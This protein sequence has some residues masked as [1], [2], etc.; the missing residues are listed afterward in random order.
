MTTANIVLNLSGNWKE[1]FRQVN[2]EADKINDAFGKIDDGLKQFSLAKWATDAA[3][4][5]KKSTSGLD[6]L[7][8]AVEEVGD[9]LEALRGKQGAKIR[10]AILDNVGDPA[11]R[12]KLFRKELEQELTG[13]GPAALR[14]LRPLN[15]ALGRSA[16]G[17][18]SLKAKAG[19]AGEVAVNVLRSMGIE[20]SS[21]A[22]LISSAGLL[23]VGA[24]GAIAVAAGGAALA[25]GVGGLVTSVRAY[26]ASSED[27][28]E[29]TEL[30][31]AQ[32]NA[33]K[34]SVG[35]LAY[36]VLGL[37][38]AL[39]GLAFGLGVA[40]DKV[41]G[42]DQGTLALA[43]EVNDLFL[44]LLPLGDV[45][46][47][48]KDL[49][50][51]VLDVFSA[52]SDQGDRLAASVKGAA[53]SYED[54]NKKLERSIELSA[55]ANTQGGDAEKTA[56]RAARRRE[57]GL[58]GALQLG[59][60]AIPRRQGGG[61]RQ[62]RSIEP[63][64]NQAS[65][66]VAGAISSGDENQE[67]LADF[68]RTENELPFLIGDV[69]APFEELA[70]VV[71]SETSPEGNARRRTRAEGD[72]LANL[73]FPDAAEFDKQINRFKALGGVLD[74]GKQ[75][76]GNFALS[77]GDMFASLAS[78][79]S[80]LENFGAAIKGAFGGL[81]AE[82]GKGFILQGVA[83]TFAGDIAGGLGLVA[84]GGALQAFGGYLG[85]QGKGGG[86]GS[87]AP[88][89]TGVVGAAAGLARQGDRDREGRAEPRVLVVGD[90]EMRGWEMDA[91]SNNKRRGYGRIDRLAA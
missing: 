16:A 23:A 65:S 87:Q 80:T 38:D 26:V 50:G 13:T 52:M 34:V 5:I 25:L 22:T 45:L 6:D 8:S 17:F 74:D 56:E 60:S 78:G 70:G 11:E 36:G 88:T 28:T 41:E 69:R 81:F 46:V 37:E 47:S 48:V 3:E 32:T 57:Q 61:G 9:G 7:R 39:S 76:A 82:L 12:L 40:V 83:L 1:S 29:R 18:E 91:S 79:G 71:A 53:D 58:R 86:G 31:E 15:D 66:L 63:T 89:G 73:G 84:A 64:R 51:G 77:I 10:D 68:A 30:F 35:E 85:S 54:F 33:L 75:A 20:A 27:A 4:Q 21:M 14:G 2:E 59:T 72:A 55:R 44:E 42:L 90:R 24:L 43:G 62:R 49:G 19:P 67:A